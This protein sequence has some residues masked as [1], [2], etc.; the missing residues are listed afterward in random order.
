MKPGGVPKGPPA[1]EQLR[2]CG[3]S[4]AP[5]FFGLCPFAL[6][7]CVICSPTGSVFQS[8]A[9]SAA[10]TRPFALKMVRA[11]CWQQSGIPGTNIIILIINHHP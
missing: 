3:C 1:P 5:R 8:W 4:R 2:C 11:L 6:C 10:G 9:R 7:V